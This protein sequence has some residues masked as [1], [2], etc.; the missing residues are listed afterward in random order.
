MITEIV[1]FNI[2]YFDEAFQG[3]DSVKGGQRTKLYIE[4]YMKESFRVAFQTQYGL[5]IHLLLVLV[6]YVTGSPEAVYVNSTTVLLLFQA[7]LVAVIAIESV[8]LFILDKK[9]L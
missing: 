8:R 6:F 5:S 2:S 9:T 4:N 7:I 1:F 3:K